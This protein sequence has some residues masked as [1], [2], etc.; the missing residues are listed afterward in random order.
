MLNILWIQ[1]FQMWWF[2][3]FLCH[4]EGKHLFG[5]TRTLKMPPWVWG[6]YN[7]E[8]YRYQWQTDQFWL[9]AATHTFFDKLNYHLCPDICDL[10]W[11]V[12]DDIKP[13]VISVTLAQTFYSWATNSISLLFLSNLAS[14]EK[15]EDDGS[16]DQWMWLRWSLPEAHAACFRP[17]NCHCLPPPLTAQMSGSWV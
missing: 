4:Y 15:Q 6:N 13:T 14:R 3:A 16:G 2:A 17:V 10:C 1:P 5:I 12:Y 11:Y 9:V 8:F 7:G